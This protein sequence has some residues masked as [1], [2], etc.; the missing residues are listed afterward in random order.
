MSSL[1]NDLKQCKPLY[2]SPFSLHKIA[3][4]YFLNT[5]LFYNNSNR[6]TEQNLNIVEAIM[7]QMR[8]IEYFFSIKNK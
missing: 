3:T 8:F 2:M 6:S 5:D 1:S 4:I 7:Q